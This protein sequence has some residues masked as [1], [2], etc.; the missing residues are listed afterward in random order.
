MDFPSWWKLQQYSWGAA[1][2]SCLSLEA[3]FLQRVGGATPYSQF[4][5]FF[6]ALHWFNEFP[7]D[8]IYHH[9]CSYHQVIT[10]V[11]SVIQTCGQTDEDLCHISMSYIFPIWILHAPH[12]LVWLVA[13][14]IKMLSPIIII[15]T[16]EGQRRFFQSFGALNWLQYSTC[17]VG[18]MAHN[19]PGRTDSW[20]ST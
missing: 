9:W 4:L 19:H 1:V 5:S 8:K 20:I 15:G 11:P 14:V 16:R 7:L 17:F 3:R 12:D 13:R 2:C 18:I 6:V 10:S